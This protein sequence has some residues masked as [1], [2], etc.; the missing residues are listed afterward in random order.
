MQKMN[1]LIKALLFV[2]FLCGS[3]LANAEPIQITLT[4]DGTRVDGSTI[5]LKDLDARIECGKADD[6]IFLDWVTAIADV[7]AAN[8][9]Q[10]TIESPE[11]ADYWCRAIVIDTVTGTESDPS[12]VIH[13][14]YPDKPS[15]PVLEIIFNVVMP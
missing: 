5:E 8:G 7:E 6:G 9:T 2:T 13:V 1:S 11:A 10:Q 15:A 12:A 14:D 3:T 4:H